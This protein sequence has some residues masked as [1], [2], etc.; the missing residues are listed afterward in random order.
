MWSRLRRRHAAMAAL[1]FLVLLV[2]AVLTAPLIAPYDPNALDVRNTFAGPSSEHW[3]GTDDL[4]RD[5]VSRL[6][7]GGRLSLLAG[8]TAVA[9]ATLLGAPLGLMSGYAG[10]W[11]DRIIT[12]FND[13]LMSFPPLIL[14]IAIIGVLGPSLINA[15]I[16]IGIV[17]APRFMRILRGA[18]L[19]V[20]QEGYIEAGIASGTRTSRILT[21]H[22]L[23]NVLSPFIVQLS[24][25]MGVAILA[26][27]GLSFI[28]LG[29]QPPQASWGAMLDRAFDH[30]SRAPL[31]VISPGLMIMLVVL[32]FNT[33]GDGLRDSL[34]R[35]RTR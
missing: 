13:S 35:E 31:N 9:V 26:E 19:A 17:F 6:L 10:G 14:A 1:I 33:L 22:V 20:R 24:I 27:A 3:L 34:G 4:G 25:G 18:T 23:P 5:M 2:V 30:M 28:G 16:A 11:W 7:Y 21:R 8:L 32:S 12:S 29:V 15:M